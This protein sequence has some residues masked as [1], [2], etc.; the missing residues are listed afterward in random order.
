MTI[1]NKIVLGIFALALNVG[2]FTSTSNAIEDASSSY[3]AF[4]END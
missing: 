3:L 1:K 4:H 2:Y